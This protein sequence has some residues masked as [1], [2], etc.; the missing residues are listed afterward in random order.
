MFNS[1]YFLLNT[2]DT[3]VH[4]R[5]HFYVLEIYTTLDITR[6]EF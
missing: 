6:L 4:N 3:N 2:H 5:K 1:D